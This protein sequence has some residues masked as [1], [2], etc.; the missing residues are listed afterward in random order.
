MVVRDRLNI[1]SC[2]ILAKNS[3]ALA[4][5]EKAVAAATAFYLRMEFLKLLL[6]LM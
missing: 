2:E 5:R 3:K 1:V 4:G 6:L